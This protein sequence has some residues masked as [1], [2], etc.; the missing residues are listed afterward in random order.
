MADRGF[1]I[2]EGVV[3]LCPAN[4]SSIS[5][6]KLQLSE[7]ELTTLVVYRIVP[8]KS[9]WVLAVQVPKMEGGSLHQIYSSISVGTSLSGFLHHSMPSQRS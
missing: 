9:P 5:V 4:H 3:L 1:D 6:V 7:E 8:G 2:K